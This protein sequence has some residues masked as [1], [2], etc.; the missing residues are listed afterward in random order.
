DDYGNVLTSVA[1]AYGRRFPDPSPLLT[2]E[3]RDKQAQILLTLTRN[4]YTNAVHEKNAYRSPLPCE[5]KLYELINVKPERHLSDVTNFFGFDEIARQA[6]RAGDGAHDIPFEDWRAKG[7]EHDVPY[8][9]LLK[10]S[11]ILYRSDRL[12]RMLP[13][14]VLE[15]LALPGQSYTL[16]FTPGLLETTFQRPSNDASCSAAGTAPEHAAELRT[17]PL[18]PDPGTVLGSKAEDGGGYLDLDNDGC[19]WVP[20][21]KIFFDPDPDVDASA[22]LMRASLNFFLPRRFENP[23]GYSITADFD[24]HDLLNIRTADALANVV[25]AEN[26]Y[27]VLRPQS[28][29][30]ANGNRSEVAFDTFGMVAGS[31]LAGKTCEHLGDSLDGFRADLTTAEIAL[32]F[33]NPAGAISAEILGRAST[34]T[35]YEPDRFFRIRQ[36]AFSATLSRETHYSDL[37]SQQQSKI[38]IS[39]SYADGFCREIQQKK[40]AE[41]GPVIDGGEHVVSRWI[42]SG[43]TIFNNKGKPVRQYEPFFDDTPGY[44]FGKQVGVSPILLYDPV[45]RLAATLHPNH[46]F[47]K[48]VFDPWRQENWDVNDNVLTSHPEDDHDVGPF[49]R[50]LPEP[51]YLPSWYDLRITGSYGFEEQNTARKTAVHGGTPGLAYADTLGNTVLSIAHNRFGSAS[52]SRPRPSARSGGAATNNFST[53]EFY[54]TRKFFD[55]QGNQREVIDANH[56]IVA[57]YEFDLRGERIHQASMEAGE[58]WLLNDMAGKPIRTWDSRQHQFRTVYD[59]LRRPVSTSLRDGDGT[60]ELLVGRIEYGESRPHPESKNLRTKVVQVMDQA[61]VVRSEDYDFKGNLLHSERQ[62]AR[63]YKRSLDWTGQIALEAAVYSNHTRYDALNRPTALTSPDHS[64]IY[65]A[66]NATNLLQSVNAQLHGSTVFTSFI[67]RINYN[68][69][70]LRTQV[71]YGND[72]RTSYGYDPLNFRLMQLSTVRYPDVEQLQSLHYT[73]DAMGNVTHIRDHAQQSIFFRNRKVEPGNDYSYDAVYRLIEGYGREHLGQ[74][75]GAPTPYSFSDASRV[76]LP[77]PGDGNAMARYCEQ[78]F[79]DAVG[80][81]LAMRHRG[82]DPSQSGWKRSYAYHETSQLQ[83]DKHS[84]RLSAATIGDH[85]EFREHGERAPRYDSHGNMLHMQ[86]L[87]VMQWDFKDQL[88]MVQRQAVNIDGHDGQPKGERTWYVYDAAGRRVRKV[89]ELATGQVKD[90]R[91]YLGSF[92]T[93]RKNGA[94]PLVRET[95]QIMDDKQPIAL[96][97]TRTE[98]S[99]PAPQQL[100]RYQYANHLGSVCLELDRQAR[101]LSYEEYTP[102]GSTAYQAVHGKS[103]A[104]KR[105]RYSGKERDEESGLYYH[106][107]RYYAPWLGLWTSADP[108]G[109]SGGINLYA[110][111]ANNPIVFSDATGKVPTPPSNSIEDLFQFIRNQAGFETGAQRGISFSSSAASPF[112]T[113]AHAGAT[114]VVDA[115]KQ[116][117]F[118]SADRIYS[119]VRTVAGVV[120]QIGGSPG[121]PKGSFNLD[122][123]AVQPGQSL[124]VG[125][126]LTSGVGQLVGDIKYGGGVIS[127]KYNALGIP[128][129]TVNGSTVASTTEEV[130]AL[131]ASAAK[132]EPVVAEAGILSSVMARAAPVLEALAPAAKVLGKIAGP[133]GAGLSAYSLGEDYAKGDVAHGLADLAGAVSGGLQTF[134]LASTALG[135]GGGGAAVGS[136]AVA[137]GG[138]VAGGGAA[139]VAATGAAV[140]GAFAVGVSV[141][142]GIQEGSAYL[143]KRYLGTEISP[144]QMIGDTLTAADNL[145]SQAWTDPNKPAY[146]QTIGWRIAAWLTPTAN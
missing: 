55:I 74:I 13:L 102:Y 38:Q 29:T 46:T 86:Q 58:R 33:A 126:N 31:A 94:T 122:L 140:V 129:S 87:H 60:A 23:F 17:T 14:G 79:Y 107:A 82:H 22:E 108:I 118:E 75:G 127:P 139:A 68:A 26:D 78:Y 103:D 37:A 95:L 124:S 34:R 11:R 25:H 114:G 93:Y 121:G 133:L 146:T 135:A 141:G 5:V 81:I 110:F 67:S 10:Q 125:D 144:G 71:V 30:D 61:G 44:T 40:Q 123:V 49:F 117:G 77:Q 27:R 63:E 106:G 72:T 73:Y 112:G 62:L 15:S 142:I 51:D 85:D 41:P 91:I 45:G 21:D 132:V 65:P 105:Y 59:A 4:A 101:I 8:R 57:T 104:P 66:Y 113:A 99:D 18:L 32:F 7:A 20:G 111:S 128:L 35:V 136:G 69:K 16:A 131:V 120:T 43:W 137:G 12:D 39:F 88:Q 119:E 97:E 89:T 138:V 54:P 83:D 116:I 145:V 109:I 134:A 19:W 100:I 53:E 70:G 52:T 76:R 80:N 143:S 28:V 3:D 130:N 36:P 84:N 2:Q 6:A 56:R 47:Q 24:T 64:V 48:T 1:I 50:R 92:E 90:E 98:G 9:R 96:I 42:A 115:L